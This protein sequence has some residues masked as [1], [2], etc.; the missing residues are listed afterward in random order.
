MSALKN[1]PP[2]AKTLD[3]R[4][5]AMTPPMSYDYDSYGESFYYLIDH[6][7][8]EERNEIHSYSEVSPKEGLSPL[9]PFRRQPGKLSKGGATSGGVRPEPDVFY[10]DADP[11]QRG[12]PL[13]Y[14]AES[15]HHRLACGSGVPYDLQIDP[16]LEKRSGDQES[17]KC[18]AVFSGKVWPP[19]KLSATLGQSCPH[20]SR[21]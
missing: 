1:S 12:V 7:S 21:A 15:R 10:E 3:C 8:K 6:F 17:Q 4:T 9:R 16:E 11:D 13:A 2:T 18:R 20:D 5:A 14:P 19:Y